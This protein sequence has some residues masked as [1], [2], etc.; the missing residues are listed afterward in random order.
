VDAGL[1]LA[2]LRDDDRLRAV[3]GRTLEA[4]GAA[5]QPR[6]TDSPAAC[7]SDAHL[8]LVAMRAYRDATHDE[9]YA[10][11]R[12]AGDALLQEALHIETMGMAY[13]ARMVL[14][15]DSVEERA[16]YACFAAEEATHLAGVS[17]H[18]TRRPANSPFLTLL[19]RLT[20]EG[21]RATLVL[22]VQVVLE[23]WGLDHYRWLARGCDD[24]D[25]RSVLE[26]ILRDEARHHGS[27]VILAPRLG[28]G[29]TCIDVL[30]AFCGM[31][32]VGPQ[33]LLGAVEQV[34]GPRSRAQ[35][36]EALRE[37]DTV[38][39]AGR[40]LALIRDLLAR[41]GAERVIH[42]LDARGCLTPL[43]PEDAA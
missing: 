12:S 11:C 10:M 27:G 21:D 7:W 20:E 18:A 9:Q 8:G 41:A 25:L 1:D 34:R 23:G 40:R 42:A 2:H 31:V 28:V 36:I 14:L 3:V 6:A 30:T 22:V 38:A 5:W 32:R 29:E 39:H 19:A 26:G 17:R 24:A 33:G 15:A 4:H 13:A 43:S 37:L 16:M 35:R